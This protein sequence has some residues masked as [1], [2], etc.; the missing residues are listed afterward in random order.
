VESGICKLCQKTAELQGSHIIPEF[1]YKPTYDAIHR[2]V[3]LTGDPDHKRFVQ[4]GFREPLLCKACEQLLNIRYEIPFR[5][6]WFDGP[7]LTSPLSFGA[8]RISG[9][10]YASFKLFHLS[11]L[12]RASV[13]RKP[14]FGKVSIGPYENKLRVMLLDGNPGREDEY[15]IIGKILLEQSGEIRYDLILEPTTGMV[16]LSKVVTFFYAGCE[17][18]YFVTDHPWGLTRGVLPAAPSKAG[19]MVLYGVDWTKSESVQG[20]V[21]RRNGSR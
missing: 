2:A 9:F 15:P 11:V 10:D 8:H 13:A 14:Q 5:Q 12:W 17:W 19:Q 16:D 20:F 21:R 4:K 1:C 6:Y 18:L 7:A 3:E